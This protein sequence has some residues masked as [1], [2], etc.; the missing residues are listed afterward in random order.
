VSSNAPVAIPIGAHVVPDQILEDFF[1]AALSAYPGGMVTVERWEEFVR[2]PDNSLEKEWRWRVTV[3]GGVHGYRSNEL[4]LDMA[5]PLRA[6]DTLDADVLE[7]RGRVARLLGV[8]QPPPVPV[9]RERV[10][11]VVEAAQQSESKVIELPVAPPPQE[12]DPAD[13]NLFPT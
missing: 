10:A 8:G 7:R 5:V 1:S 3:A 13:P 9:D 6:Q 11:A 2:Q 4:V 12:F